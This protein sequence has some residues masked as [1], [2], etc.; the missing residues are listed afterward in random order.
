LVFI[1]LGLCSDGLYAVVGA[2]AGHWFRARPRRAP[3][4]RRRGSQ[5]AEGGLLVGLGVVAL[6][7]PD[8]HRA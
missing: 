2:R 3:A 7:T 6:A 8:V 1:A 5:L 4:G